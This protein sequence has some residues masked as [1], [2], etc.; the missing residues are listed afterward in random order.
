[1]LRID[2]PGG[3]AV[4]SDLIWREVV[5]MKKPVMASMSDVAGSGG[6]YIAM[7]A[8][9]IIAE[10]DTLTGSIGVIGG[11]MVIGGLLDKIGVTTEI[12][13]RGK[14]S[15]SMSTI[16]PFTP[17]EREAWVRCWT[18]PITNS[19]ARRPQGRK[20]PDE[21]AG[22]AGPR[23]DLHRADGRGQRPGRQ[24]GTLDRRHRRGE[25]AGRA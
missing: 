23:A 16:A 11:K 22:G 5:R 25:E 19:S 6:Y 15:G 2:S 18:R 10:P 14:N 20:M 24:L 4:A 13:A 21:E 17:T 1:M 8:S 9:K 3:S 12:I 7:G